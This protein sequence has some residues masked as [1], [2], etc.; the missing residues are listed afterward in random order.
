MCERVD[1][2][3]AW[4]IGRLVD[5]RYLVSAFDVSKTSADGHQ[6][7]RTTM[8][9]IHGACACPTLV[10]SRLEAPDQS[11]CEARL[12]VFA[13]ATARNGHWRTARHIFPHAT[14]DARRHPPKPAARVDPLALPRGPHRDRNL[15]L[16][17]SAQLDPNEIKI[18][19][20]RTS[21]F[22]LPSLAYQLKG[23]T[24]GGE[25]GSSASLAPKIGP[26]GLVRSLSL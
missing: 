4:H 6:C 10:W 2:G 3:W 13:N 24:A 18:I 9:T 5:R 20:I 25:V 15:M 23:M 17:Y 8:P 16:I 11:F 12:L 1:L 26:L 22:S 21:P 19:Y 14:L 7:L